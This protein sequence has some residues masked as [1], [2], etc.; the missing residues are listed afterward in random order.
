MPTV[1]NPSE[2]LKAPIAGDFERL[3]GELSRVLPSCEMT[4]RDIDRLALAHDASH[5]LMPLPHGSR[6]HHP[7]PLS[8]GT[9]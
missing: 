9:G 6:R 5:Y 1:A 8:R 4:G 2:A 7:P 3:A